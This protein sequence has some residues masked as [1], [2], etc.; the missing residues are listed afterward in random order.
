MAATRSRGNIRLYDV[1]DMHSNNLLPLW[2]ARCR[3]QN[4]TQGLAEAF[5]LETQF[6]NLSYNSVTKQEW[7]HL[8]S[9]IKNIITPNMLNALP[10]VNF[11]LVARELITL[12]GVSPDFSGIIFKSLISS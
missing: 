4:D 10:D 5:E 1:Y 9:L 12:Y 3:I 6:Q 8:W 11:S 7:L 2:K